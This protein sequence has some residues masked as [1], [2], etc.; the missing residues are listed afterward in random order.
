LEINAN[1]TALFRKT[2]DRYYNHER[3]HKT[4]SLANYTTKTI[5]A[6]H[7][8]VRQFATKQS[9]PASKL[10]PDEVTRAQDARV[11]DKQ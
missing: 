10:Q 4:Q 3:I 5:A 8:E 1:K 7:C 9:I 6:S 2:I 11:I